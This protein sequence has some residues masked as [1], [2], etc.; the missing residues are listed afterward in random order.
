MAEPSERFAHFGKDCF[1][2]ITE[3]KERL[4]AADARAR[5]G[6]RDHF[7]R[8]HRVRARLTGVFAKSAVAAI[9]AAQVCERYEYLL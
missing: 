2:A 4:L 1:G 3:A 5:F 7:V 8:R 6:D 9:V